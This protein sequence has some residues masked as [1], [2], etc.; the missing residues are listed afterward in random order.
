MWGLSLL[1]YGHIK[2]KQR[3]MTTKNLAVSER[4]TK[5][6]YRSLLQNVHICFII[7]R[8]MF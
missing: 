8:G 4:D 7:F 6:I 1:I 3:K 2:D 5:T